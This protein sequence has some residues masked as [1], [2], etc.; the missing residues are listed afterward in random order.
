MAVTDALAALPS[1]LRKRLA[2]VLDSEGLT[3]PYSAF[4]VQEVVGAASP[5][6]LA[7]LTH[8]AELGVTNRGAAAWIRTLDQSMVQTEKPDLVWSGPEVSG[9]HARDTG[10]VYNELFSSAKRSLWAVSFAYFDGPSVFSQLAKRMED[11]P[12]LKVTLLLNI[13][14]GHKD[15]TD[16]KHL[17]R[18]FATR[19]WEKD[20]PG[21]ARPDV[22][23]DPRSVNPKV[24]GV[25]HAK[26][27]V[28]DD[29]RVFI[30]SANFTAAALD[31]NIE[32]GLLVR[33]RPLALSVVRHLQ[34]LIDHKLLRALP[35]S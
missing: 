3:V 29:E 20:W 24:K 2:Q 33:H 10:R 30:T 15:T 8:L 17:V 35:A 16:P 34:G 5:A 21:A 32:L 18:E 12:G 27:V 13:H 31:H 28:A 7:A 23:Y 11:R 14:R 4:A 19:F 9:L 1:H 22:F 6:V 26:A 25:L